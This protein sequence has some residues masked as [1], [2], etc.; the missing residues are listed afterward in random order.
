TKSRTSPDGV[1]SLAEGKGVLSNWESKGSL[2]QNV[3]LTNRNQIQGL[4][5][6]VSLPWKVTPNIHP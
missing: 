5:L 2:R 4:S 6:G 3:D 1:E